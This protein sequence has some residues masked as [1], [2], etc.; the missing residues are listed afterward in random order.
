MPVIKKVQSK[1]ALPAKAAEETKKASQPSEA[2]ADEKGEV[3]SR[4][5][6][7]TK[8]F[9]QFCKSSTEPKYWDTASLRRFLNDRGRIS[10][11]GRS[12][13]CAK[14]QRRIS[15]EIKRARHLALLPFTVGIR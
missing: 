6:L 11:R 5:T 3:S 2:V 14:H 9:C 8:K 10:S 7:R 4:E 12:G 13:C 15:R 1:I